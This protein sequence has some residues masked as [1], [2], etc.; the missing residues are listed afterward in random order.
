[1]ANIGLLA[2]LNGLTEGINKGLEQRETR[3]NEAAKLALREREIALKHEDVQSRN[4][5]TAAYQEA[6][7]GNKDRTAAVAEG[8]L[9][10]EKERE[11]RL[12]AQE[13]GREQGRSAERARKERAALLQD[14][15]KASKDNTKL[16][17][18]AKK[19]GASV[20]LMDKPGASIQVKQL[21]QSQKDHLAKLEGKIAENN[22]R[23][24]RSKPKQPSK[25]S[26]HDAYL[27]RINNAADERGA[28]QLVDEANKA[29]L[30]NNLS[31][32]KVKAILEAY[33]MKKR[34][35]SVPPPIPFETTG[36]GDEDDEE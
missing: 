9:E 4:A 23:I 12:G 6:L 34:G 35:G 33:R 14:A 19:L 11:I 36:V 22:A 2:V 17:N 25:P 10:T 27:Q 31:D 15:D 24:E 32:P 3:K 16:M 28:F 26:P 21:V 18:E 7:I 5:Q 1:M 8:R 29:G 13:K 20:A 30:M